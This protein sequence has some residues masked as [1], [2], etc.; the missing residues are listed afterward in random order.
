M[1][2]VFLIEDEIIM[3]EGIKNHINWSAEGLELVGE[4][5]DGELAYP[6]IKSQRPD[7]IIT[8]IMMPFM[9]GL[10][11]S[12]L[13]KQE[14]PN[15]KIVI[16]SGYDEFKFAKEAISIGVTEYLVK[17][18]SS[19][20]LLEV[21][22]KVA[23][24]IMLEREQQNKL[25]MKQDQLEY[26]NLIRT[27]FFE[28]IISNTLPVTDILK[29]GYEIGLEM[30]AGFYSIIL[31]QFIL[32]DK[33]NFGYEEDLIEITENMKYISSD[34]KEVYVFDRGIEGMAFLV[35]GNTKEELK[36]VQDRVVEQLR[37]ILNKFT[38]ICYFCGIGSMVHRLREISNSFYQANRALSYRY[39]MEPNKFIYSEDIN[40][41]QNSNKKDRFNVKEFGKFDKDALDNFLK[42]GYLSEVTAFLEDYL[43]SLG[44]VNINSYLCRQYIVMDMYVTITSFLTKLGQD[45]S[46]V[47]K[48]CGEY[49]QINAH[50]NSIDF[51]RDYLEEIIIRAITI[52][53]NISTKKN[54]RLLG[55]ARKYILENYYEDNISLNTVASFVNLSPSH[56]SM[57][58]SQEVGETFIEFLTKVRI[59]KAK[60]LL[61]C[62]N[63][64]TYEVGGSVGYKDSHY[65][66]YL[67]KK[68]TK[69]TPTEFRS[70]TKGDH[71]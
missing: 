27:K 13:I 63:M 51:M 52:R 29:Q 67:F 38:Y 28:K 37:K 57:I 53:D 60:E 32:F 70:H 9:N 11:L 24:Q 35:K 54:E 18:I 25:Q 65:F 71:L 6:M 69:Y 62:T 46:E 61:L 15:I 30:S 66:S 36:Q 22:K 40:T 16:L 45:I 44:D 56:F 19:G 39:I 20:K 23:E 68:Y 1:I 48:Q 12:R 21:I 17:P 64:K 49:E 8:D 3:R 14:M 47:F 4:A 5:S 55:K 2:K 33:N 34:S 43:S 59:E 10:E 50:I 58:F 31:F 42:S 7:I 26:E 41:Y